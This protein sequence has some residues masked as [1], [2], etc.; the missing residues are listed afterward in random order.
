[1]FLLVGGVLIAPLSEANRP[2]QNESVRENGS[3]ELRDMLTT[4]MTMRDKAE[5]ENR[6]SV[7]MVTTYCV[8]RN[9]YDMVTMAI[10]I[11]FTCIVL[12]FMFHVSGLVRQS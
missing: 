4:S 11:V 5:S 3:C 6:V 12:Y 9:V 1:M 10:A 7:A 2:I 8:Y